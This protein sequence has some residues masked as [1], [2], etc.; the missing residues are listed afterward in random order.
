MFSEIWAQ[1]GVSGYNQE[2]LKKAT[3]LGFTVAKSLVTNGSWLIVACLRFIF[4]S[5]LYWFYTFKSVKFRVSA[6]NSQDQ[7]IA[8]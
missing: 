6:Y 2:F 1:E 4:H 7:L 5:W 3:F 8:E